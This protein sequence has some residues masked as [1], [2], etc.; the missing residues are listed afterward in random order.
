MP[1]LRLPADHDKG[2]SIREQYA[3]AHTVKEINEV[4]ASEEHLGELLGGSLVPESDGLPDL[5][6]IAPSVGRHGGD[7]PAN[8]VGQPNKVAIVGAGVT[9]LFLG[10]M[11]DYLNSTI[12]D[13]N[14]DY[15]IFEAGE[16]TRVGGR[17]FTYNFPSRLPKNPPGPHDYYDV[18]GM[19]FPQNPVMQRVFELFDWLEMPY[20]TKDK[21]RTD[22]PNGSLIPYSMTNTNNKGQNEPFRYNDITRWGSYLDIAAEAEGCDAFGFN[23]DRHDPQIPPALLKMEPSNV[24]NVAIKKLREALQ[25]DAEHNGHEGWDELMKYDKYTTREWMATSHWQQENCQKDLT[26]PPFNANTVNFLETMNGGT[27]WYDQAFSETVLESLDFDYANT[28]KEAE[29]YPWWCIM[30]GAQQLPILMEKKLTSKPT[31]NSTVSAIRAISEPGSDW[32]MEISLKNTTPCSEPLRYNGVFNTTTLGCL[33][34]IDTTGCDITNGAKMAFRSLAYGQ[35]C[36]VGIKFSHAWWIHSLPAERR[37]TSGGLGHSDLHIRTV[38]YPSYNIHDDKTQPAVLLVSYTW[39]QDAERVGALIS[40]NSPAGENELR[41]LLITELA[42]LHRT[43]PEE[44]KDLFKLISDSYRD[45]YAH[46]WSHDPNT[47]GA[48]AF[49]RAQ[50]FSTLWPKIVQPADNLVFAGEAASPHHAWVVGAIESAVVALYSW[51]YS[52]MGIPGAAEA[53]KLID[54]TDKAPEEKVPFLGLPGYMPKK[55][56][57]YLGLISAARREKV[58]ME[59][60]RGLEMR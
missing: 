30:G 45:H 39:Q 1:Y 47:A 12:P 20:V 54:G 59:R 24:V 49:F 27:D 33:R 22:T 57:R 10:M 4:V 13:F 29:K 8:V 31:Y 2:L 26:L 40:P 58:D 44:E 34:R 17:L 51:L 28:D 38:V 32:Q 43:T 16:D 48:F 15:D 9:G 14:I 23:K 6:D 46:D 55:Q 5:P 35:S 11:L 25:R 60:Q 7:G 18:G 19:R 3:F 36:K 53:V 50:Q 56:A 21:F 41:E 52:R 37:I 42:R